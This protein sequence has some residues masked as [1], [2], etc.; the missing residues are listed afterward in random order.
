MNDKRYNY[1]IAILR[2]F[3]CFMVVCF[4]FHGIME[5]SDSYYFLRELAV[6]MFIM[7]AF[8]FGERTIVSKDKERYK[9]RLIR[10]LVPY[11]GWAIILFIFNR[12]VVHFIQFDVASLKDLMLQLLFGS[13]MKI[14]APL[15]FMWVLFVLTAI[16]M[17]MYSFLPD[18]VFVLII[19]LM[20]LGSYLLQYTLVNVLIWTNFREE[21][22][23]SIGR[24]IE[25]FPC[26]CVGFLLAHYKVVEKAAE[27]KKIV[28]PI[29][30]IVAVLVDVFVSYIPSPGFSFCYGGIKYIIEAVTLLIL[31]Y[32]IPFDRLSDIVKKPIRFVGKYT[33]GIYCAHWVVGQLMNIVWLRYFGVEKTLVECLAIFVVCLIGCFIISLI[34]SKWTKMLVE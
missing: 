23:W 7:I 30:A 29:L 18:K 3:F 2:I 25:V 9:K 13:N 22:P 1:G 34:P 21:V 26:A 24:L 19:S 28:I 5:A 4:H 14:D 15:W 8:F 16:F 27:H 6:P 17:L 33:M 31:F 20:A 11:F 32:I 10:I 12:I